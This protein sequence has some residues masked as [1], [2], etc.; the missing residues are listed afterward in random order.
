MTKEEFIKLYWR[1]YKILEKNII[2]TDDYVSIDSKNYS[3]FSAHYVKIFLTECSEIDSLAEQ[4]RLL[5]KSRYPDAE[6]N[7]KDK[8]IIKKISAVKFEYKDLDKMS[9]FTKE[10]YGG[11]KNIPFVKFSEDSS[12]SWWQ[13]YNHVKHNRSEL[14]PGTDKYYYERAN[15]KNCLIALSGLYLL[16]ILMY[17]LLDGDIEVL[18]SN[19]F[20]S[21]YK[22]YS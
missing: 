18:E 5:I 7:V 19:L 22:M 20:E 4:M 16:C 6:I 2:E 1:Q 9:I 3:T 14:M 17:E 13:D 15:L 11:L 8:S 10:L 12:D 21:G